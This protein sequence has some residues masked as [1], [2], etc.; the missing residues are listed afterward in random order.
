MIV[1]L[2]VAALQSDDH[3]LTVVHVRAML[4]F[5][6][7]WASHQGHKTPGLGRST[8][9]LARFKFEG[10]NPSR[11]LDIGQEMA[12]FLGQSC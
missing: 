12:V 3:E 7:R 5:G 1:L 8:P 6:I 10:A 11:P 2:N 9:D 4:V